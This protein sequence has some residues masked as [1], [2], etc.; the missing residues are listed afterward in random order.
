MGGLAH[1]LRYAFRLMLRRPGMTA[2]AILTFARGIG[3]NTAIF[4]VVN[5]VLLKPLPYESSERLVFVSLAFNTGFGDRTS[6]PMSDFLAW[7]AA[8]RACSAVA[9]YTGAET[10]AVS[11]AGEAEA[12]VATSATAHFFE[13][14]GIKAAVGRLWRAGDDDPGAPPTV[15]VSYG[16]W[17]TRLNSDPG[18]IG[19]TLQIEGQPLTIIGVAPEGFAF[20]SR[21]A[22]LWTILAATPPTRRGPFFLRG[23]GLMGL[24][25]TTDQ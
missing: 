12:V 15:I 24:G 9:A 23:L 22:Q 25:A 7:R 11:N 2:A 6:L 18:A 21:R 16:Y 13:V 17:T 10:I 8:N 19:R 14:L 20:P 4:S 5:A 3:A 1:D